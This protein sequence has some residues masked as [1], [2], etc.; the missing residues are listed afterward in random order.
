[1]IRAGLVAR[2][3]NMRNLYENSLENIWRVETTRRLD[4]INPY[5]VNM[6]NMVS[7]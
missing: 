1:M 7:S 3:E 5:P 6:E 2:L 4:H